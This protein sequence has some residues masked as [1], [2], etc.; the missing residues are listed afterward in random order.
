MENYLKRNNKT[1]KPNYA[2]RNTSYNKVVAAWRKEYANAIKVKNQ[3]RKGR[4]VKNFANNYTNWLTQIR[5]AKLKINNKKREFFGTLKTLSP[6]ARARY[7]NNVGSNVPTYVKLDPW[8]SK[9]LAEYKKSFTINRNGVQRKIQ[10]IE[11]RKANLEVQRNALET[12]ISKLMNN[13]RNIYQQNPWL[14]NSN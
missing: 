6:G 2:N 12:Q 3:V 5:T 7:V 8:N 4:V 11:K 14:W 10:N 1:W 9:R 13:Y